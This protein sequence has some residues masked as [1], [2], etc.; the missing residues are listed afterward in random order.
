M[1]KQGWR[2]S[3]VWLARL[4]S[5]RGRGSVSVVAV[6]QLVG[7][8]LAHLFPNVLCRTYGWSGGQTGELERSR[9]WETGDLSVKP[10]K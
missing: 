1:P 5:S 4:C 9:K 7:C 2:E 6:A 3:G 10:E 8:L